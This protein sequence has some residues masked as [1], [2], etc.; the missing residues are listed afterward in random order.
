[1][2]STKI[3]ILPFIYFVHKVSYKII[4]N[5]KF[6]VL[7]AAFASTMAL[8]YGGVVNTG[9]SAVSRQDDVSFVEIFSDFSCKIIMIMF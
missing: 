2:S 7:A 6:V 9:A 3:H 8:P 1:M 4:V 5:M